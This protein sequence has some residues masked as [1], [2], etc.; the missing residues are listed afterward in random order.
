VKFRLTFFL[1]FLSI[2]SFAQPVNH[3]RIPKTG[4][5]LIPP[6]GFETASG[7]GG[8]QD[9]ST[10]S[11]IMVNE[12]FG[13]SFVRLEEGMSAHALHERNTPMRSK[14][15]VHVFNG[16]ATLI[17]VTENVD[18]IT[19]CK[20][21]L[22]LGD[23]RMSI[24]VTGI[25]VDTMEEMKEKIKKSMLSL[26]YQPASIT[27]LLER[28]RFNIQIPSSQFRLAR[29]L[30]GGLFYTEDGRLP[31]KGPYMMTSSWVTD[32]RDRKQICLDQL[33][34]LSDGE[35]LLVKDVRTIRIADMPGYEILAEHKG[36]SGASTLYFQT[37]LFDSTSEAVL[38]N[39]NAR[40]YSVIGVATENP[41]EN[42]SRFRYIAGT[43]RRGFMGISRLP[44]S[45][46][47]LCSYLDEFRRETVLE[48]ATYFQQIWKANNRWVLNSFYMDGEP[49]RVIEFSDD[50]LKYKEGFAK[51]WYRN[52]MLAD[53]ETYKLGFLNGPQ[54]W[55]YENGQVSETGIYTNGLPEDVTLWTSNGT[56][57]TGGV[58]GEQE[59]WFKNSAYGSLDDYMAKNVSIP[60]YVYRG[61]K[62]YVGTRFE[63][64]EEGKIKGLHVYQSSGREAWDNTVLE[65]I[66]RT[67][68]KPASSH[69]RPRRFLYSFD[70]GLN[71]R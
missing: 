15:S 67:K 60:A 37:V 46:D 10:G 29:Y 30:N 21:M 65:A 11:L 68:W 71:V 26:I 41:D 57:D 51:R 55:Y 31:T 28:V 24:L 5:Y 42:I 47:T 52:G 53:S 32:V 49:E 38:V 54:A 13:V 16:E 63:I 66:S 48:D 64:T 56:V 6:A 59:V 9:T 12:I 34:T 69:N 45:T 50:S 61:Q 7:F 44:R 25:C 70:Y 3:V 35:S 19:N 36:D 39:E 58:P 4:F 22:L 1:L 33:K 2:F 18:G 17:T 23:H 43:L 20:Q 14:K 27:D 62:F 8:L 40:V